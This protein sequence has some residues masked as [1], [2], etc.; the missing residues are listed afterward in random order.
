[1]LLAAFVW[2]RARFNANVNHCISEKKKRGIALPSG[3]SPVFL[4]LV[5][6]AFTIWSV[7]RYGCCTALRLCLRAKRGNNFGFD[8]VIKSC[9][10]RFLHLLQRNGTL[11]RYA[12]KKAFERHKLCVL[13]RINARKK[14]K[15]R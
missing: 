3:K 2:N 13:K 4:E 15:E 14:V 6:V 8:E 11:D 7:T 5:Q 10:K 12:K 1:M 9:S